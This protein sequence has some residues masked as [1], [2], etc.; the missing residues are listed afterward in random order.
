MALERG[1]RRLLQVAVSE[2]EDLE[3]RRYIR[4]NIRLLQREKRCVVLFFKFLCKLG[5]KEFKGHS[6]ELLLV[7][8]APRKEN[9]NT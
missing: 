9:A 3:L 2:L 7:T 1:H 5:L 8:D 6:K 4:F